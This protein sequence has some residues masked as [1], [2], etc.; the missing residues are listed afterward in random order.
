MRNYIECCFSGLKYLLS[1]LTYNSSHLFLDENMIAN[2]NNNNNNNMKSF[3]MMINDDDNNNN[4]N[5]FIIITCII[6]Y[7][8]INKLYFLKKK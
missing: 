5:Y 4:N 6:I 3:I 1:T 2:N 7:N 8:S